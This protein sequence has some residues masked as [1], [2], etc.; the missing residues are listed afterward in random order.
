MYPLPA[1]I[2]E[3]VSALIY[4]HQVLLWLY[5]LMLLV[6][7]YFHPL[8]VPQAVAN[9]VVALSTMSHRTSTQIKP[10]PPWWCSSMPLP[11][12][13]LDCL[14]CAECIRGSSVRNRSFQTT[15]QN[16]SHMPLVTVMPHGRNCLPS[17]CRSRPII[18]DLFCDDPPECGIGLLRW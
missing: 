18:N 6:R 9:R 10:R 12:P 13:P 8:F 1:S 2:L 5:A 15:V 16:P 17:P 4:F 11:I 3:R 7:S 14:G